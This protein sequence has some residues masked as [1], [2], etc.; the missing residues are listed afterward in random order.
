[1]TLH[2]GLV[3]CLLEYQAK[4]ILDIAQKHKKIVN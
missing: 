3:H 2:I 4:E 1:M